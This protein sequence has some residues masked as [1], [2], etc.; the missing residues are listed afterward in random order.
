MVL[1]IL[2]IWN[3][4]ANHWEFRCTLHNN[5]PLLLYS[6]LHTNFSQGKIYMKRLYKAILCV[7][8]SLYLKTKLY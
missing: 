6:Y 3:L 7:P 1:N 2:K 4:F 5:L 8:F